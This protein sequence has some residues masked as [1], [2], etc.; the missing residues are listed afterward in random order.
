LKRY[1]HE[2]RENNPF[3]I[4]VIPIP[5]MIRRNQLAAV[6][7]PSSDE[8]LFQ[9]GAFR[10]AIIYRERIRL[11]TVLLECG[12]LFKSPLNLIIDHSL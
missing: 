3:R 11:T 7:V 8:N 6:A 2:R 1:L 12:L 5:I 4:K 9:K 10:K